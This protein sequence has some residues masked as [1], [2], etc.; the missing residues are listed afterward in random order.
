MKQPDLIYICSQ[1]RD[2]I[3]IM[4]VNFKFHRKIR[5]SLPKKTKKTLFKLL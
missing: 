2:Y 3:I 5:F 1:L 4:I